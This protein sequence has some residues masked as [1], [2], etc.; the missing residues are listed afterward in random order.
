MASSVLPVSRAQE[1]ERDC[2]AASIAWLGYDAQ[3]RLMVDSHLHIVWHNLAGATLLA[4][5]HEIESVQGM[6]RTT[7]RALRA[8]FADFI[9][10][11][12]EDLS[13]WQLA[14]ADGQGFLLLRATRLQ[15]DIVGLTA[16]RTGADHAQRF[17]DLDRAF[18]LTASEHRVLI[19]LLSGEEADKLARLHGVSLETTRTHIRNVYAKMGVNSRESMFASA[20]PFRI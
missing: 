7:N 17:V 15:D 16:V 19:G 4:A 18:N 1:D 12:H 11:A 8:C 13:T 5:R 3:P 20:L 14:R 2:R 6:L 10:S 9:K